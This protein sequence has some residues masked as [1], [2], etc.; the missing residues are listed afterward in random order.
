MARPRCKLVAT[1]G[2]QQSDT[3]D[4][5]ESSCNDEERSELVE[6][7]LGVIFSIDDCHVKRV[8]SLVELVACASDCVRD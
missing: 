4:E 7:F 6:V 3:D 1:I 2:N 8:A 5:G